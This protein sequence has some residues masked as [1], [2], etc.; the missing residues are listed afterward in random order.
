MINI[1]IRSI[2]KYN[3]WKDLLQDPQSTKFF[4]LYHTF[5][6]MCDDTG[7]SC[8]SKKVVRVD[9]FAQGLRRFE[10]SSSPTL[11]QTHAFPFSEGLT[12]WKAALWRGTWESWWMT[13]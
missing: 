9:H 8:P 12:C 6:E 4:Y 1:L 5:K 2:D 13:S 3:L 10:L 11:Y 7:E